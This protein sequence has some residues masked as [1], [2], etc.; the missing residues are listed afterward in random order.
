[1]NKTEYDIKGIKHLLKQYLFLYDL[2]KMGDS[3]ASAICIDLYISLNHVTE[4]Q[5][6][7]IFYHCILNQTLQET[8]NLLN[9]EIGT[10]YGS[11]MGGIKK[12]YKI[13]HN[14]NLYNYTE[15][16]YIRRLWKEY[17]ND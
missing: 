6:Y 13:L 17:V 7:S 3:V 9:I 1:M 12:I 11:I 8:G 5:F 2:S 15:K 14:G 10:V 4:K 16:K